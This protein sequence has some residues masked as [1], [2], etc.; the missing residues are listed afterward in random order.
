MGLRC[1]IMVGVLNN[2]GDCS[3]SELQFVI[4]F[5]YGLVVVVVSFVVMGVVGVV[6][7]ME[8][9]LL[10]SIEVGGE[11]NWSGNFAGL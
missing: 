8:L 6:D 1:P 3:W 4:L 11:G 9:L 7:F 2:I 5:G 10:V